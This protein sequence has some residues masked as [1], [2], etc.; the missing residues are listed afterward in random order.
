[1]A[2]SFGHLTDEPPNPLLIVFLSAACTIARGARDCR[3]PP[4]LAQGSAR[5]CTVGNMRAPDRGSL[6]HRLGA[7]RTADLSAQVHASVEA[8]I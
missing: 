3:A 7:D 8:L 2:C 1:M 6:P 4:L 5:S